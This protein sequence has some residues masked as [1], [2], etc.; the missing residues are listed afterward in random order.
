MTSTNSAYSKRSQHSHNLPFLLLM[1]ATQDSV[2]HA[3]IKHVTI[4]NV[5]EEIS[6]IWDSGATPLI[7]QES[8]LMDRFYQHRDVNVIDAKSL[9]LKEK[10]QNIP[11]ATVMEG[12]RQNLVRA[13]KFGKPLVIAMQ[14]SAADIVGSYNAKDSFPVPDVF[15]PERI[16]D[17]A[18]WGQFV[19][20]EDKEDFK[21]FIVKEG[22]QVVV[23]SKFPVED[24]QE[25]LDQS[26]PMKHCKVLL[27]TE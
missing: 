17:E 19:K 23:T 27:L 26:I 9:F 7:L 8:G 11:H 18:V 21:I 20:D 6:A 24:Y 16:V 2:A 14:N 3:E 22:F 13:M 5:L 10:M 15:I 1:A 12:M 25:F 4:K